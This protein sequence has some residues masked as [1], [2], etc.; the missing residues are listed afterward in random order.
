[1]ITSAIYPTGI[2]E[3]LGHLNSS[4]NEIEIFVEDTANLNMWRRILRA[5]LPDGIRFN[6]PI[7]LGGR[8]RVLE[9]CRADQARDCRRRLYIIDADMD[10]LHGV[11]KPRLKHLY[12]IRAYCI[13]N[14]LCHQS[15]L[16]EVCQDLDV[17]ASEADARARLDL[18][19]WTNANRELMEYL[20]VCY[21]V[22]RRLEP[23]IATVDYSFERLIQPAPYMDL[24]CPRLTK[25]R[26]FS[27]LRE[28]RRNRTRGEIS[29]AFSEVQE[30][31]SGIDCMK[32]VSGKSFI[33]P[34]ILKRIRREFGGGL[35]NE[36]FK[37]SFSRNLSPSVD[38]Y[39]AARLKR[40]CR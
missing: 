27:L 8:E 15:A 3:S 38:P 29:A 10:F 23:Q 4:R 36:Q 2:A 37:A 1:M 28:L 12:R 39:L 13:E 14:Y 5:F 7:Q 16:L 17:D 18:S 20:F 30:N 32:Y 21:A 35:S 24:L 6:D 34:L 25:S 26:V 40:I 22:V 33:L 19:N 11:E 31:I 9:E